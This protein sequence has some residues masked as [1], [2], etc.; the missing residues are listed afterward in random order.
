[1]F[2]TSKLL[3]ILVRFRRIIGHFTFTFF[4][5]RFSLNKK[6]IVITANDTLVKLDK[7]GK[8]ITLNGS[9]IGLCYQEGLKFKEDSRYED[10][11]FVEFRGFGEWIE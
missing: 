6:H 11:K 9:L 2:L 3:N 10:L 1:M 5:N 4:I 7:I 8:M